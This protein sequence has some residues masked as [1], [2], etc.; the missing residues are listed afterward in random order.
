MAR[1]WPYIN[2][3]LQELQEL[4]DE[5]RKIDV[6]NTRD[7]YY[8]ELMIQIALEELEYELKFAR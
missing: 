7:I 3:C 6:S 1:D 8:Y 4:L 2:Q 5:V